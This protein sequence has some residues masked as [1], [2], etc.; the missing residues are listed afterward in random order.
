MGFLRYQSVSYLILIPYV[1][2]KE[3]ETEN[4]CA[5]IKQEAV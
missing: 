4:V 2:F 1:N 5:A 3:T